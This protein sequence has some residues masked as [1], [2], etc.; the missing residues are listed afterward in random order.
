MKLS[1][2]AVCL[3][4]AAPAIALDYPC[5]SDPGFCY[6]DRANDGCFDVGTDDAPSEAEFLQLPYYPFPS[7]PGSV[8]CPPSVTELKLFRAFWRL[9]PGGE[10]LLYGAHLRVDHRAEI[11]SGGVCFSAAGPTR[12]TAPWYSSRSGI[13]RLSAASAVARAA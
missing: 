12:S 13:S 3:L 7:E 2:A 4:V 5:P 9:E 1:L 8:I 6:F 10:V 11:E